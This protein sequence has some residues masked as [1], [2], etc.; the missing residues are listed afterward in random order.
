[1]TKAEMLEK[2]E[3]CHLYSGENWSACPK[4]RVKARSFSGI[5]CIYWLR[6]ADVCKLKE[7]VN[8][9]PE[10]LFEI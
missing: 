3:K 1:M 10:D 4:S 6:V 7:K 9:L 5:G 8:I 2:Y